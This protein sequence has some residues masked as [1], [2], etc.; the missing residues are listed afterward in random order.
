MKAVLIWKD[1][2]LFQKEQ[3]GFW[4]QCPRSELEE[5]VLP[6]LAGE[7][8]TQ[9]LDRKE[10]FLST[11]WATRNPGLLVEPDSYYFIISRDGKEVQP[12]DSFFPYSSQ[13][14]GGCPLEEIDI[15]IIDSIND[16]NTIPNQGNS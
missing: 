2:S 7:Q 13:W 4:I 8:R 9:F 12:T 15:I 10:Y 16:L 14:Y 11:Q 1:C 5:K 3:D 6:H